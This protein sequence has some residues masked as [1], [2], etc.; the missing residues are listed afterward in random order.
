MLI[1]LATSIRDVSVSRILSMILN[2]MLIGKL[3]IG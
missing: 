1:H 3:Y 2:K